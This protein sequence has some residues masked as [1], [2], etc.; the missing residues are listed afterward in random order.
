MKILIADDH[1]IVRKGIIELLRREFASMEVHEASNG[2]EALE[3]IKDNIWDL[4]LLDIAMPLK[5]GIDTL[6][7]LRANGIKAPVLMLSMQPEDQYAIR[8]IKA[9]ASGFVNKECAP[10]E[11]IVAVHRVLSGRKYFSPAIAAKL[12]V[13]NNPDKIIS[14]EILSDR[15]M[16][17]L[18][19]LA[20]GK[21]VSA[22]AEEISLSVPTVSTYRS[23][24]LEKLGLSTSADLIRYAMENGLA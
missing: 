2:V 5:K 9:G 21:T 17:V 23:H 15:E 3:K 8:T 16:Q 22:I 12:D 4:I 6:K 1:S 20:S 24:I 7:Q 19:L 13:F 14:H 11:L 10:E 18:K